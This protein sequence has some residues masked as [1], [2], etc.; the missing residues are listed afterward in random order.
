MTEVLGSL[1]ILRKPWFVSLRSAMVL[2]S[3]F[4]LFF[5]GEKRE[6]IRRGL[7]DF[8]EVAKFVLD[9]E[10]WQGRIY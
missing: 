9:G 1:K 8:W 2:F 10:D 5:F 3:F 4:L 7:Q 6:R